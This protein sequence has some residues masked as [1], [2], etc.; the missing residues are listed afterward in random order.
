MLPRAKQLRHVER[1]HFFV[2]D[3]VRAGRVVVPYVASDANLADGL[4]KI[5][6]S[7]PRF[8]WAASRLRS[9]IMAA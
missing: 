5:L 3:V 1:R 7:A 9:W 8:E 6:P 4:T 2:Q